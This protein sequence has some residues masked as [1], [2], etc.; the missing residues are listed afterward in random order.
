MTVCKLYHVMFDPPQFSSVLMSD[1]Q[2]EEDCSLVEEMRVQLAQK[3]RELQMMK[4][5]AEELNSL[6]QQN[7][8]LQSKVH[9]YDVPAMC[10]FYSRQFL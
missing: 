2:R 6:R 7:Y 3:E 8:L 5:G 4:E 9:K 1:L 10:V